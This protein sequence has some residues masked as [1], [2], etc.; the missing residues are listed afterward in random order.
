M[1]VENSGAIYAESG[2]FNLGEVE[3]AC[4]AQV[5]GSVALSELNERN[6]S[7]APAFHFP[8]SF[9]SSLSTGRGEGGR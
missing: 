6:R 7:E 3:A 1:D 5:W 8:S 2:Y 9:L 4:R